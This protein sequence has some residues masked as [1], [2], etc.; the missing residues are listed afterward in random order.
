MK[1]LLG[2]LALSAAVTALVV[3]LGLH[4]AKLRMP[5]YSQD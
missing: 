2:Y 3:L 1:F 5:D 4:R